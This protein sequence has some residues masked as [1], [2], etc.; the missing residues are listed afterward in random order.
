VKAEKK[1]ESFY[2]LSYLLEVI[3][4][5]WQFELFLLQNLANLG[6]FFNEKSFV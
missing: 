6:H 4:K 3:I 2:I 1:P 5:I